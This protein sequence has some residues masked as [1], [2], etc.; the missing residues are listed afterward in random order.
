MSKRDY[1]EVLGVDRNASDSDLKRAYRRMAHEYHPDK[2]KGEKEVEERFKEINE[3]YGVLKDPGKRAQY[4]RFGFM[5]GPGMGDS[6][7][8]FDFQ[9][10]FGDIFGDFF[11]GGGRTSRAQRGA[12][13]AYELEVTFEEAAFGTEKE[14]NIPRM[15]V[16]E[17]CG[18]NGAQRGTSPTSCST[19]GGRGQVRFQQGLFSVSRPCSACRGA[20]TIIKD[21][22]SDCRGEG[23]KRVHHVVK[24]KVPPG[25]ET[26]MRLRLTG[27]GESGVYGAPPGDL[28]VVIG[29][30]PHPIFQRQND[31]ILCEVPI[32]FTQ[33]ALGT[34]LEVPTLEGKKS[35]K[36]PA[37][38]QSG[39]IFRMKGRGVASVHT[40]RRGDQNVM[41]KV[42]TPT[43]LSAEQRELFEEFARI[44]G[45]EVTPLR[46]SFFDK[47]KEVFE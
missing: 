18:G 30:K 46:K 8:G 13:L 14:I 29:A 19:C 28:Y 38:T 10:I 36:I 37:G 7:S 4:D 40:G 5:G 45:D 39:A 23:R 34:E 33:A 44:S 15:T 32:S 16:C 9:D 21:P 43:K 42:E 41:V 11:G 17:T 1:Y 20:G 24:V 6:A 35:L 25:V 22:C 12:D 26:G 2:H 47:V 3:A 31:D 27:E